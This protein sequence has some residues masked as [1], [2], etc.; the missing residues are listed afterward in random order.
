MLGKLTLTFISYKQNKQEYSFRYESTNDSVGFDKF[1]SIKKYFPQKTH[2]G[3]S[4]DKMIYKICDNLLIM[5]YEMNFY[6]I[7]VRH[8]VF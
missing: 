4:K 5:L 2:G 6:R 1:I 7:K 3:E 8:I